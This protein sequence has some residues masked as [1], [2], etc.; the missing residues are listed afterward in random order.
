MDWTT[1][2]L[3]NLLEIR[4]RGLRLLGVYGLLF[5]ACYY[6]ANPLLEFILNPMISQMGDA[7][8]LIATHVVSPLFIP[9]K[10]ASYTALFLIFPLLSQQTFSFLAPALYQKEK[11]LLF[12]LFIF[13]NLLFITGILFCYVFIM[14]AMFNIFISS[15][16]K[17]I[18]YMPDVTSTFDFMLGLLFIFGLCFQIPLLMVLSVKLNWLTLNQLKH[19]RRY[20]IVLAFIIGMLLTP[21]DV[22]SQILLAL[23]LWALYELGILLN[24]LF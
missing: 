2:I 10:L 21:P 6:F 9:L 16:P 11:R 13:S 19:F 3:P 15:L 12:I 1:H 8:T 7:Q 4:Q 18:H 14:P 22:F 24:R 17:A 5:L 20:A 23:P